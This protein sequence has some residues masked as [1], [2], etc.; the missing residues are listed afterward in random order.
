MKYTNKVRIN[1]EEFTH[2]VEA[3]SYKEALEI[4]KK[5]KADA[6]KKGREIFGKLEKS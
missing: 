6:K 3:N 1:G 2:T 4:N 5:R